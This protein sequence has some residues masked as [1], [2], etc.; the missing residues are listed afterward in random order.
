[1][2]WLETEWLE[3]ISEEER[4]TLARRRPAGE[5]RALVVAMKGRNGLGAKGGRKVDS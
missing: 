4:R 1:M 2:R 5:V 3:G